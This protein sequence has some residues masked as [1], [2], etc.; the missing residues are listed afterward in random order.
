M[1]YGL[2]PDYYVVETDIDNFVIKPF[3]Y[4]LY[5]I[6]KYLHNLL[7]DRRVDLDIE[8]IDFTTEFNHCTTLLYYADIKLNKLASMG[9][10][11]DITW[12]NYRFQ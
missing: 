12:D 1:F 7:L 10:H 4:L 11:C 3:N 8:I 2:L 6:S 5:K 9:Y